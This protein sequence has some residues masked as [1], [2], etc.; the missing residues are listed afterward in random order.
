M[1][2]LLLLS[3][4]LF[5]SIPAAAAPPPPDV[6]EL[7]LAAGAPAPSFALAQAEPAPAGESFLA[8][9]GPSL[10]DLLTAA[11][12]AGIGVLAAF[13]RAKSAESKAAKVGLV[14]TEAARAAV[15]ELD[16]SIKPK[17]KAFLADGKL[18]DEEKAELKKMALDLLKTKLPAGLLTA[19]GGVFGAFTDTYLAGKIEQ[20]VAEKNAVQA[21]PPAA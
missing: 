15:L 8:K 16:A 19:A 13:L 18:S 11:A 1:K 9:L 4:S 21:V 20:A 10:L 12:I 6:G 2:T 5:L 3:L 17:L 7:V 14:V